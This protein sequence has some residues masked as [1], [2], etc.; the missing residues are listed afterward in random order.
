MAVFLH[1]VIVSHPQGSLTRQSLRKENS[2]LRETLE[3]IYER[4]GNI[5]EDIYERIGEVL[6]S[7]D[8]SRF[9]QERHDTARD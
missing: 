5:L 8:E 6:E 1:R 9:C 7:D 2:V 4:I 3:D